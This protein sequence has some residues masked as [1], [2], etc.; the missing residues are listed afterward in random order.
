M[1]DASKKCVWW[2]VALF[3][4]GIGA[5]AFGPDIYGAIDRLA[6]S[7]AQA[8][9]SLVNVVINILAG[10][11]LPTGGAL[12]GAAVVTN[13]LLPNRTNQRQSQPD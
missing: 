3:V 7:N 4:V 12:I 8:G 11:C 10:I 5:Q 1:N 6:G 9:M 2:A 13:V